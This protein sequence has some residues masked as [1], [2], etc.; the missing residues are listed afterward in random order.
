MILIYQGIN[1]GPYFLHKSV[2]MEMRQARQ[3]IILNSA[4][5]AS[6]EDPRC[7]GQRQETWRST[8]KI[9]AGMEEERKGISSHGLDENV[10]NNGL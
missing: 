2:L 1:A 10:K 8:A 5:R 4:P 7:M 3:R 9:A 6:A